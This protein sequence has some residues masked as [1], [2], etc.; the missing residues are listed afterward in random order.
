MFLRNLIMLFLIA[1][2]MVWCNF[3]NAEGKKSS[4]IKYKMN[5]ISTI[6]NIY[7]VIV[8]D[9]PFFFKVNM[10]VEPSDIKEQ[11]MSKLNIILNARGTLYYK[12]TDK[13]DDVSE[14]LT[15]QNSRSISC[16]TGIS[17]DIDFKFGQGGSVLWL[18][19][20]QVFTNKMKIVISSPVLIKDGI[21]QA[22]VNL[23]SYNM[24]II[25]DNQLFTMNPKYYDMTI[26]S[27]EVKK[28]NS[29]GTQDVN[30]VPELLQKKSSNKRS[31]ETPPSGLSNRVSGNAK[32]N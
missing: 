14:L 18:F 3:S 27:I 4:C 7:S 21:Y 13:E 32:N 24:P 6:E 10:Y 29:D 26:A 17:N 30:W 16:G 22:D 20:P 19:Y 1:N 25:Y 2:L 5:N 23:R 8:E 9:G 28:Q 31:A 15:I 12:F 11:W